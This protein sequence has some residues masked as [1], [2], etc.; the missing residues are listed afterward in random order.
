MDTGVKGWGGGGQGR[1]GWRVPARERE[2]KPK[3][4]RLIPPDKFF[5]VVSGTR[6]SP[7]LPD[8]KLTGEPVTPSRRDQIKTQM[9]NQKK[10]QK[11]IQ[12]VTPNR[13][14]KSSTSKETM[15]K[16]PNKLSGGGGG[17][18]GGGFIHIQ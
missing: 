14:I 3:S 17:G 8:S 2:A 12:I 5:L 16:S 6:P 15:K 4:F 1:G 9:Y 7:L 18:G 11:K 13:R 10:E